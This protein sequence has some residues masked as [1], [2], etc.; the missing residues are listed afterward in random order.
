[1]KRSVRI[2]AVTLL[3]A[4]LLG[5]TALAYSTDVY[6]ITIPETYTMPDENTALWANEGQTANVNVLVQNNTENLNPL[7]LTE[8]DLKSL[9][10]A[11]EQSFSKELESYDMTGSISSITATSVKVGDYNTVR[12]DMNTSYT[13]DSL[14]IKS[15]QVQYLFF[16]KAHVVYA[17]I[18]IMEGYADE[19]AEM[20]VC[21]GIVDSI[22]L[23][24]DM[25]TEATPQRS[26]LKV[27]ILVVVLLAAA[28]VVVTMLIRGKKAKTKNA[29]DADQENRDGGMEQ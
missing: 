23:K 27:G 9:E 4:L 5:M 10:T 14:E 28:G 22:V 20:A 21:Q 1:M 25:Y 19:E 3:L 8:A 15:H 13:V 29:F 18:T 2:S 17:T 6:D 11:T 24:E 16:T 7:D 12:I 26:P